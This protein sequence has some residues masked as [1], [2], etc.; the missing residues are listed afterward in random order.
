MIE[1]GDQPFEGLFQICRPNFAQ[2]RFQY[3]KS[4]YVPELD[5]EVMF[6]GCIKKVSTLYLLL[7]DPPKFELCRIFYS[8]TSLLP[9][10][11]DFV[12]N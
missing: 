6:R 4:A 12:L 9:T 2:F 3:V 1:G 10:T 5:V 7:L 8:V 11:I